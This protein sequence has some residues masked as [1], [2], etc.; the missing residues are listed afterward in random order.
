MPVEN[1][2]LREGKGGNEETAAENTVEGAI[3]E[4]FRATWDDFK[5]KYDKRP[6]ELH[7]LDVLIGDAIIPHN[8]WARFH[9]RDVIHLRDIR[10]AWFLQDL[11]RFGSE[12]NPIDASAPANTTQPAEGEYSPFPDRIRINGGPLLK[13][14]EKVLEVELHQENSP[15]VL[16]RPFKLL[17]QYDQE[18]RSVHA[19]L[20]KKYDPAV[21]QEDATESSSEE[22][23]ITTQ[24]SDQT[25]ISLSDDEVKLLEEFGS[26]QAYRELCCLIQFMNK[27]L[28]PVAALRSGFVDKVYYSDL[29][30]IFKPGEVVITRQEPLHAYRVLYVSGG[31]PYLSPPRTEENENEEIGYQVPAKASDFVVLCYQVHYDGEKFGPVTQSF[32]VTSYSGRRSV[33]DLPVYPLRLAEDPNIKEKLLSNGKKYLRVSKGTHIQYRGPNLH[34][35][36]EI[37]SQVVVDFKT[38]IWDS[39]DKDQSWNYKAEFGVSPPNSADKA[40]VIMVSAGGCQSQD[41]CEN[42]R[43]FNDLDIDHRM[44]EDFM[45]KN[46]LLTTDSRNLDGD[47][48]NVPEE[49]IIILPSK[50]FAF[51]LKDRN[52]GK[53][54]QHRNGKKLVLKI[55]SCDRYQSRR[56]WRCFRPTERSWVELIGLAT[57]SQEDGLFL[58]SSPFPTP[59]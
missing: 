26:E 22:R 52:W 12:E 38:A 54:F 16:L 44:M 5:R 14:L 9:S 57:K 10:R 31:R 27:D 28:G 19:Q 58:G 30:H 53:H 35:G 11:F 36:E 18:I 49:D 20:S 59:Q 2:E 29:W 17:V 8:I 50:I 13:L 15:L 34:E 47:P 1:T 41:C 39:R 45:A 43:I 51:V 3:P 37:D 55:Y 7:A 56:F 33:R 25:G 23:P 42:D 21:I 6:T 32:T 40:E 46:A 24:V 4:E 48:E